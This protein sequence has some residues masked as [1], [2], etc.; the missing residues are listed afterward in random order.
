MNEFT[1]DPGADLD[2]GWDW[3][4][5]LAAGET[6]ISAVVTVPTGLTKGN[7]SNTSTTVTVWLSGGTVSQSGSSIYVVTCVITTNQARVDARSLT[8][9]VLNR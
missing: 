5:W 4:A 8:I 3:S 9:N 1:K 2:Y 6:I 7:E